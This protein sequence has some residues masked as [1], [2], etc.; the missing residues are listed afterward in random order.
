MIFLQ[1]SSKK[2]KIQTHDK[3]KKDHIDGGINK[4]LAIPNESQNVSQNMLVQTDEAIQ[5][6]IKFS[7]LPVSDELKV[8]NS[9]QELN[10]AWLFF[11]LKEK[12]WT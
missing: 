9:I 12:T 8:F 1:H 3:N 4:S 2:T 6:A 7:N 5:M 11:S 10:W